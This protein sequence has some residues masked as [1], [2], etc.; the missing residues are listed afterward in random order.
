[1]GGI[2]LRPSNVPLIVGAIG[3]IVLVGVSEFAARHIAKFFGPKPAAAIEVG[4]LTDGHGAITRVRGSNRDVR[5]DQDPAMVI[6]DGDR[7]ETGGDAEAT[8]VLNSRDELT[9]GPK[10]SLAFELWDERDPNSPVY[11][12]VLAG[13]VTAK[14]GGLR[15]RAYVV[16]DGRLYL[17][18]QK[19]GVRPPPL[20]INHEPAADVTPQPAV[21]L[22]DAPASAAHDSSVGEASPHDPETLANEYVDE[23]ILSRQGLLQKCWMSRLKDKPKLR[24]KLTVQFEISR[25]GKVREATIVDS[26]LDDAQLGQCVISVVERIP[27]RSFTGPEISIAYPISFE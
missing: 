15:G 10:S 18:G 9:L 1:M 5:R 2:K 12:H 3:L 25:R 11:A 22:E 7:V 21:T 26:S 23:M 19:P 16:R 13:E 24:G 4:R 17:P 6:E 14:P 20:L 27:F 8:V